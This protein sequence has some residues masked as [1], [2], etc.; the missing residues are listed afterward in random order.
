MNQQKGHKILA[1]SSS[2]PTKFLKNRIHIARPAYLDINTGGLTDETWYPTF[3]D[4]ILN[5]ESTI[6]EITIFDTGRLINVDLQN[7]YFFKIT[8]KEQNM[9]L[10]TDRV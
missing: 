2:D 3:R 1:T 8:T 4:N 10:E 7:V 6:G 9:T 5:D